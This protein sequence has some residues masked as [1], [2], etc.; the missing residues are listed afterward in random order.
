MSPEMSSP[1][2]KVDF[3]VVREISMN[4]LFETT[5][6]SFDNENVGGSNG[7][8]P[9]SDATGSSFSFECNGFD[10]HRPSAC[11]IS[12]SNVYVNILLGVLGTRALRVVNNFFSI[13]QGN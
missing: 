13:T 7:D 8:I 2:E 1:G 9:G 6:V 4:L 5:L 11:A 12:R 3:E 10:C